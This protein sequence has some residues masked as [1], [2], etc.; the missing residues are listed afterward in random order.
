M[1]LHR[2]KNDNLDHFSWHFSTSFCENN[3]LIFFSIEKHLPRLPRSKMKIS[4]YVLLCG[5]YVRTQAHQKVRLVCL[6]WVPCVIYFRQVKQSSIVLCVLK[7]LPRTFSPKWAWMQG[8]Q[9]FLCTIYQ[10]G[11]KFTNLPQHFQMDVK[12]CTYS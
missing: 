3:H 11:R 1:Y 9:S 5:T 8:C 2:R 10:K 12:L 4:E 7:N 6:V